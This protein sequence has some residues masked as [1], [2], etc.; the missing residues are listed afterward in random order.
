MYEVV[1]FIELKPGSYRIF[2]GKTQYYLG[3][4]VSLQSSAMFKNIIA[5]FPH[6]YVRLF[7]EQYFGNNCIYHRYITKEEQQRAYREA[8]ERR[9]LYQIM[10]SILNHPFIQN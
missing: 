3:D 10:S 9:A 4:F 2:V 7:Q 5:Y 1:P 8:F 6:G